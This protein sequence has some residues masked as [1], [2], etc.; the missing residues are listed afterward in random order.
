MKYIVDIAGRQEGAIGQHGTVQRSYTV[1]VKHLEDIG[2]AAIKAAYDEGGIEH[3]TVRRVKT[4]GVP[5]ADAFHN[6][7]CDGGHCR[8]VIGPVKVYPLGA[9]GNLILCHACWAHENQHRHQ[10]GRDTGRPEDWPQE[11]WYSAK[12]YGSE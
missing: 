7:N 5:A 1:D 3:V 12:L 8:T 11:N 4:L 2:P 10:R 6:P 9:G